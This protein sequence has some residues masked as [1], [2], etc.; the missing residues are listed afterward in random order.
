MIKRLSFSDICLY[1]YC[2]LFPILPE[3]TQLLGRPIYDWV[4]IVFAICTLFNR[5]F[6][7]KKDKFS[8]YILFSVF[9]YVLMYGYHGEWRSIIGISLVCFIPMLCIYSYITSVEKIRKVLYCLLWGGLLLCVESLIEYFLGFN[10]FSLIQTIPADNGMGAIILNYRYNHVRVE[11]TM[12]G[13]SIYAMYLLFINFTTVLLYFDSR[14]N[15]IKLRNI[16]K[17]MYIFTIACI[18]MTA[19]RMV[20]I[21]CILTQCIVFLKLDS[22]KKIWIILLGIL[23]GGAA[24]LFYKDS[25]SSDMLDSLYALVGLFNHD[26]YAKISDGGQNVSYRLYLFTALEPYISQRPITGWGA[27]FMNGFT[28]DMVTSVSSWRAFS[29]DNN[30]LSYLITYGIIGLVA[31]INPMIS[32]IIISFKQYKVSKRNIFF[33][34]ALLIVFIYMLHLFSVFQMGEKRV[35]F[36]LTAI[37]WA[38]LRECRKGEMNDGHGIR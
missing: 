14:R 15:R 23:G 19:T 22:K 3:F 35:F 9:L 16:A 13:S 11:A 2:F 38:Y 5:R 27:R 37:F 4:T 36:V 32:T 10:V 12:G 26:A 33:F 20:I 24:I 6:I 28:F 21:L 18:F 31:D 8:K 34:L 30:Y 29:I 17:I 7:L 1:T 25:S